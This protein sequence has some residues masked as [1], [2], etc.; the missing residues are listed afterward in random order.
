M[1]KTIFQKTFVSGIILAI[2]LVLFGSVLAPSEKA[3]G[4]LAAIIVLII[5]GLVGW[6]VPQ[7]LDKA[8][9]ALLSAAIRFGLLAGLVF[10]AEIILEYI[11]LPKDNTIYGL[12]EFAGVFF[13]YFLA[14]LTSAIRTNSLRSG[15][16]SAVLAA[17]ISTLIWAIVL[18]VVFYLFRGTPQQ[19]LVFQA[20]GDYADFAQSGAVNFNTFIVEDFMGAVFYHSLLGPLIALVLG[21]VGGLLAKGMTKLLKYKKGFQSRD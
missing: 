2:G 21:T 18:L 5:Y 19:N 4:L 15:V 3:A 7:K 1:A 12:V 13:L 11:L 9:P 20:E 16:L 8:N 10:S 14:G 17:L 6:I